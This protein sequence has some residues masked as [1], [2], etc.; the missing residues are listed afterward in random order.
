[1]SGDH[2]RPSPVTTT[3]SRTLERRVTPNAI[4][5]GGAA[6][7]NKELVIFPLGDHNSIFSANRDE[8]LAR[9]GRF[10]KCCTETANDNA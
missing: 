1:M 9:L 4:S 8:Y 2:R 10:L 5:R 3:P 6:A 7:A